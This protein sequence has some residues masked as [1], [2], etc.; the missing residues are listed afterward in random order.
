MIIKSVARFTVEWPRTILAVM[1][2]L[3]L[4]MLYF[5]VTGVSLRV[6]LDEMLPSNHTNVI[7]HKKFGE[8]FGGINTVLIAVTNK[9]G[10]IYDKAFL[11]K[12]RALSD[13][14]YFHDSIYR[15]LSEAVNMRKVRAVSGGG[16]T[17][18]F[19]SIMWP[20]IPSTPEQMARFRQLLRQQFGGYFIS[21]D[22]KSLLI[23][24]EFRE[25]SDFK[26]VYAFLD[27]LRMDGEKDGLELAMVG[28]PILLGYIETVMPTVL[29]IFAISVLV[30][31]IILFLYFKRLIGVIAPLGVSLAVTV[32]GFGVMGMFNYN[33]DPLLL[34]LPFF[35]FATVLSHSVQ[36]ISRVFEELD[37][38]SMRDIVQRALEKFLFPSTAAVLTDAAGFAV[39]VALTIPSLRSLGIVCTLWLLSLTPK[40]VVAGSVLALSKKPALFR[41]Y[42][43]GTNLLA[44]VASPRIGRLVNIPVFALLLVIGLIMSQNLTIGDTIGSP[45]LW[46][47]SRYNKDSLMVNEAFNRV[48]TD[49]MHVYIEGADETMLRPDVYHRIEALDRYVYTHV[50]E[51]TPAQ[52]LVGVIKNVNSVLWE[53]DPSYM[54]IPDSTEEIGMNIY[55]FRSRGEAGDFDIYTDPEWRTGKIAIFTSEHSAATVD[56]L[57]KA[58]QDFETITPPMEGAHF[59]FAGGQIGVTKAINDEIRAKHDLL[60]YLIVGTLII[61]IL[62]YYQSLALAMIIAFILVMSHYVSTGVMVLMG[63]GMNINT[64]PLAALGMGRGVDYSIYVVD[65]IKEELHAGRSV[66]EASR[67][68]IT[69]SGQA[70]LVTALTMIAPLVS[71]Y[72]VSPIRFQ[73]EMGLLLAIILGFNMLGALLVVPAGVAILRPRRF[74]PDVSKVGTADAQNAEPHPVN[75]NAHEASTAAKESAQQRGALG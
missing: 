5:A 69:T 17:V 2:A 63:I 58:V 68:A 34:L 43:P 10:T 18:Q 73:A 74:F 64:L 39:L 7:A 56:A 50:M 44:R 23:V 8:R 22:E 53:G 71:W 3:T 19:D 29:T 35:V 21:D 31:S 9:N 13:K 38:G 6:V 51:A 49:A 67:I 66:T 32:W 25:D 20:D 1:T 11:E 46:E 47:N 48:G 61:S 28:R 55:M 45:I 37:G 54:T 26:S 4:L 36:F 57:T 24:S 52:S 14:I 27:G 16:G 60:G 12:Y 42:L 15:P 62:L 40:I 70:V 33:L 59:E 75:N 41:P 65:R 30:I 72:F